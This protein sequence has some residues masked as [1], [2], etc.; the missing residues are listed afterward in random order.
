ISDLIIASS[1]NIPDLRGALSIPL[2][3]DSSSFLS[4][5]LLL[6]HNQPLSSN[7]TSNSSAKRT[8]AK[9]DR[10][11]QDIQNTLEDAETLNR[12]LQKDLARITEKSQSFSHH[13]NLSEQLDEDL[14]AS[15]SSLILPPV[16]PEENLSLQE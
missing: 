14:L 7:I 3:R 10:E 16:E 12:I 1:S 5:S 8:I 2:M 4:F 6:D 13:R 15:I 11:L 9:H